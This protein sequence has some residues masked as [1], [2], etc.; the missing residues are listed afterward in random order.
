VFNIDRRCKTVF[1]NHLGG[2]VVWGGGRPTVTGAVVCRKSNYSL[3][4][5]EKAARGVALAQR[6]ICA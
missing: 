3:Q 4:L 6:E 1:L 2:V 5:R